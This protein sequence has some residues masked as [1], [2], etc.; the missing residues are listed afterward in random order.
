MAVFRDG[1]SADP[2]TKEALRYRDALYRGYERLSEL[3]VSSRLALEICR[4]IKNEDI[5]IR[6]IPGTALRSSANGKIVYT[7]PAGE[8]VIRAKLSNWE[9][10]IHEA[11]HIDPLVRMAIQHYQFEAIHPFSDGNGRTGRILNILFLIEQQLL[12]LPI[13]YLSRE[14]LEERAIYYGMLR[15]VTA[16]NS[17]EEWIIWLLNRVT[18]S[19]MRSEEKVHKI[20]LLRVRP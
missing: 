16:E 12:D 8:D 19:A 17:W 18:I 15:N 10:F 1:L 5:D 7:P 4:T 14:I 20:R 9:R 2:A 13:L 3:P 11:T 6:R